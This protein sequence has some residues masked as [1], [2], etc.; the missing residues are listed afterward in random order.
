MQTRQQILEASSTLFARRGYAGASL[1]EIAREVGVTPGALNRHFNDKE[2]LL[3]AVLDQ[4]QESTRV[5][6]DDAGVGDGLGFFLGLVPLMRYHVGHP[7]LIELFLTICAE[8]STSE[9]PAHDWARQRYELIV[10]QASEHLRLAAERGEADPMPRR[11]REAEAR[12]L[13]ALMDGLELQWIVRPD[14]DLVGLFSAAL[15]VVLRSWGV[16]IAIQPPP[17]ASRPLPVAT[18]PSDVDAEPKRGP[19]RAGIERRRQILD[20]ATTAFAK[21]GYVGA[22]LR[23]IA[24]NVGVTSAAIL[25]HF[26]SKEGLLLAVLD[27]WDDANEAIPSSGR[28]SAVEAWESLPIAMARHVESPGFIELFLTICTEA[29]DPAHPA[30]CWVSSRYDTLMARADEQLSTAADEGH[31][32]DLSPAEREFE[33]RCIYAVMD[34]LEL[35]WIADP[36]LDLVGLFDAHYE[37]VIA[38]LR[39]DAGGPTAGPPANPV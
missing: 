6:V 1:R 15:T 14:L 3:I 22:S 39:T 12:R 23:E 16:D 26:G 9:H 37:A 34:G 10:A 8:A 25:R 24:E 5:A 33:A 19:Y 31:I 32:R 21:H 2:Q 36:E 18:V 29:S 28:G 30:R 11:R 4:W 38:R 17:A 13:F 7:G 20:E 27:R 35:Q